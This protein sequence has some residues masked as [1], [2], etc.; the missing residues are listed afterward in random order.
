MTS[1]CTDIIQISNDSKPDEILVVEGQITDK[2]GPYTINLSTTSTINGLGGNTLGQ[3]A[4]VIIEEDTGGEEVLREITPGVYQ[5][6]LGETQGK[7]GNSYRVKISLVNGDQYESVFEPIPE[8]V[9]I[10]SLSARFIDESF[11]VNGIP[12]RTIGHILSTQLIKETGVQKFF[13][14]KVEGIEE[15]EVGVDGTAIGGPPACP[16]PIPFITICYGIRDPLQNKVSI[17]NDSNI[18]KESYSVDITT[19]PVEQKRRYLANVEVF[20]FSSEAYNFWSAIQDQLEAEGNIFDS[21]I[22][23]VIG[24]VKNISTGVFAQGHFTIASVSRDNIC[25][26]RENVQIETTVP[27]SCG[28]NN[29]IKIWAPATF[30]IPDFGFCQ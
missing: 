4:T 13:Q 9:R 2:S 14:F 19:I 26:N 29:C 20:S 21:P 12:Q 18:A 28:N 6:R 10:A 24:N 15:S 7:I 17:S 5:T 8:P 1:A 27:L 25:I 30:T 23:P 3:G 22:P 16:F 11:T